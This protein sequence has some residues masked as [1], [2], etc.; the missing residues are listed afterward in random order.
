MSCYLSAMDGE[1]P[2]PKGNDISIFAAYMGQDTVIM[3]KLIGQNTSDLLAGDTVVG[4]WDTHH[5][6]QQGSMAPPCVPRALPTAPASGLPPDGKAEFVD[7]GA[8]GSLYPK[9]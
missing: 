6:S 2:L 3:L 5:G 8:G 9:M 1:R 7:V 4:L